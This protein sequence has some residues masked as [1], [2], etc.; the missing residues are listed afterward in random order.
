MGFPDFITEAEET[1]LL[2][3]LDKDGL[4][5]KSIFNGECLSKTWGAVT[6]LQKRSVRLCDPERGERPLPTELLRVI[7]KFRTGDARTSLLLMDFEPNEAN[8]NEYIA[9]RGDSL[10]PHFFD[11]FLSGERLIGL[12]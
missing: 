8:A 12:S 3:W 11:R 6:D 2:R 9:G 4:W 5:R 10:T 1:V 7:E